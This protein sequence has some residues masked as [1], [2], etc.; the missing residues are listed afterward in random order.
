MLVG[1]SSILSWARGLKDTKPQWD[2]SQE[3]T[4]TFYRKMGRDSSCWE[5]V[6]RARELFI[7]IAA[8]I[9]AYLEK[10]S[11]PV[12]FPV[13]WTIYMIGRTRETSEPMIMFCCRDSCS[14]K[15]VRKT[16][17][18]SGILDQYQNVRLGDASRPP[19]FD[20]LVQL[21]G[22]NLESIRLGLF[23]TKLYP[24]VSQVSK[25]SVNANRLAYAEEA[26]AFPGKPIAVP[27]HD[28]DGTVSSVRRATAGGILRSGE[29]CFYLTAGHVFEAVV[30]NSIP[31]QAEG[32]YDLQHAYF[33]LRGNCFSML[34]VP[35]RHLPSR[36]HETGLT[37]NF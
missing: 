30:D 33:S 18:E 35:A 13:T 37:Q 34:H 6:G 24:E 15:Q 32:M 7:L 14:R 12:P 29:R 22:K 28:K 36:G 8:E 31:H 23:N 16:V 9:K 5:A 3:S 2:Y 27:I 11:D 21:A 20:Q 26:G 4:G 25:E 19:D 1:K 10:H 17:E